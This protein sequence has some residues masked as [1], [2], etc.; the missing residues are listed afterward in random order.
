MLIRGWFWS[1]GFESLSKWQW[2]DGRQGVDMC[3]SRLRGLAGA[4]GYFEDSCASDSHANKTMS[5]GFNRDAESDYCR[6]DSEV[7][8]GRLSKSGGKISRRVL[9][10]LLK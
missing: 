3:K 5:T 1:A 2:S 8:R 4:L 10:L 9:L 7:T 6:A